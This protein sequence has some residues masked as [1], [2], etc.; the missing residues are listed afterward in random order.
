MSTVDIWDQFHRQLQGFILRRVEDPEDAEDILQEVFIKIHTHLDSLKEEDRL[1]PW[2]YQVT[3]NAI[4]DFYR[5]RRPTDALPDTL[6]VDPEP[7]E[8][9]PEAR[10]AAGLQEMLACL[11]GKYR[12]ALTLTEIEGISQ[13]ELAQK[14]GLSWSGAK[15]RVQRGR[16]MLKET[17]L[18]CCHFE[19][20]R[21][22]GIIDYQSRPECCQSCRSR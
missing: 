3:R 16:E 10:I 13:I 17:L 12:T 8:A 19:F 6:A 18:A 5:A 4:I 22:G 11:P 21:R 14:E 2:L 7:V 15:S 1:V 9:E 20:D